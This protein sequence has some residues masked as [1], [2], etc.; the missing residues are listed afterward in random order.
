LRRGLRRLRR[1]GTV[2]VETLINMGTED[3]RRAWVS[4]FFDIS[5]ALT[6]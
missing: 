4:V 2:R 3:M 1:G 6:G 5:L